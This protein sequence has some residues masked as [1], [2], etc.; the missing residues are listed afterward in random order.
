MRLGGTVA[1]AEAGRFFT[2]TGA[3]HESLFRVSKH[4]GLLK[5]PYAIAGGM[6]M[7]AHGFTQTAT[8]LQV[9]VTPEH[10]SLAVA[11]LE[12]IGCIPINTGGKQLRDVQTGVRI[13]FLVSGQFSGDGRPKP[14]SFPDPAAVGTEI[15]GIRYLNLPTLI[16]LKLASGMTNPGRLKDLA[17]VQ[18]LIRVLQ[19]TAVFN[20]NLNPFVRQKYSELWSGVRQDKSDGPSS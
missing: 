12:Q 15:D 4:F 7:V 13:E 10:E 19:L 11:G 3:V 17:D 6:A 5:I 1:L 8:S 20:E 2:R 18:E 14:V 16:E 9:L